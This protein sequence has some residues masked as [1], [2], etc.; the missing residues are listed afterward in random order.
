M[1]IMNAG[2]KGNHQVQV[3]I[4][5]SKNKYYKCVY[6]VPVFK[7][8]KQGTYCNYTKYHKS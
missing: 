8:L 2:I 5:I 6:T 3:L 4:M 1:E 7:P